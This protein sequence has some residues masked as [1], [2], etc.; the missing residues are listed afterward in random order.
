V[1]AFFDE[2]VG[3]SVLPVYYLGLRFYQ[4]GPLAKGE[5]IQIEPL[6]DVIDQVALYDADYRLIPA[7]YM[8]DFDGWRQ[9]LRIPVTRDIASAYLCVDLEFLSDRNESLARL[10]RL[11]DVAPPPPRPQTVVLHFGGQDEV[12]FRNGYLLPAQVGAI[13]DPTIRQAAVDQFCRVYAPY[14][15]TVLTDNDPV[16]AAPFSVIY[17]GPTSL[18]AYNYGLAELIDSRNVYL[19]DVAVVDTDQIALDIARLLGADLYGRAIGLIAAH[20]MGH[21]LGLEHVADADALMTGVQCQGSGVDVER[22]LHRQF[23]TAPIIQFSSGLRQWTIGYQDAAA[24]LLET[25]GPAESQM[26]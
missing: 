16:P 19:D 22:M 7:G 2:Q 17:I 12:T 9:T 3:Q 24:D 11:T 21:L 26:K 6:G 1:Q 13:E 25:V 10:T 18:A 20:E 4:L 5:V 15:V 23:R 8:R 14:D